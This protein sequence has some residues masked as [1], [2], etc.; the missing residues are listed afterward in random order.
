MTPQEIRDMMDATADVVGALTGM[1]R[2]FIEQ[3]WSELAAEQLVVGMMY[4]STQ[5]PHAN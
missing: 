3:G 4:Q 2:Q 1:K 5:Q